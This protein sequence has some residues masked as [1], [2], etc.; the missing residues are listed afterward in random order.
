MRRRGWRVFVLAFV[1][2]AVVATLGG[3][4]FAVVHGGTTVSR[5]VAYG[6]WFAAALVLVAIPLAGSR[7]LARRGLPPVDGW[8]FV[9]A[10]VLL[11]VTGAVIDAVGTG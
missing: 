3:V 6:F 10:A 4:L 1:G 9:L 5:A 7:F 11:T 2:I 8:V